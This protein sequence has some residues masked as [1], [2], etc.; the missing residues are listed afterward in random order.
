MGR[1]EKELKDMEGEIQGEPRAQ[2][3]NNDILNFVFV[4]CLF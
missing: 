3:S 1:I 4:H 2:A